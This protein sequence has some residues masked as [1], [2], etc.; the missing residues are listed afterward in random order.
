MNKEMIRRET[1]NLALAA[2]HTRL[3]VAWI[4]EQLNLTRDATVPMRTVTLEAS[5]LV[6][7]HAA[8]LTGLAA[9]IVS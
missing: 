3:A 2:I 1:R 7:A 4:F 5:R 6:E 8:V 9:T